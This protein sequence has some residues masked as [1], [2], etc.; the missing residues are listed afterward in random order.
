MVQSGGL[1]AP[2]AVLA[3]GTIPVEVGSEDTFVEMDAGTPIVV[4]HP[5]KPGRVTHIPVP[6][7][8]PGTVLLITV[9]SGMNIRSVLVEV[10]EI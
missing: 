6:N 5:V 8:P 9:G 7:V 3:G 2:P 4:R 10:I 1:R